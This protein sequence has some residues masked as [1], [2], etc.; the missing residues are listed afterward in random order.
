MTHAAGQ[1]NP[2]ESP[3]LH[4]AIA[5]A[6]K[7][8]ASGEEIEQGRRI[9]ASIVE[10]PEERRCLRD[11]DA[12]CLGRPGTRPPDAVPRVGGTGYG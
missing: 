3:I 8:A 4:A 7:I 1:R 12:S 2:T 10:G 9:P 5:L 6:P 11:G